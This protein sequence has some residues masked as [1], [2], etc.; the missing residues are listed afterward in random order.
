L[1]WELIVALANS[2]RGEL[3]WIAGAYI[4]IVRNTPLLIQMYIV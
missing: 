4:Q 2:A 1:I 3:G